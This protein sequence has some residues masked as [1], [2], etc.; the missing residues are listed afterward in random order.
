VHRRTKAPARGAW[1]EARDAFDAVLRDGRTQRRARGRRLVAD[2]ADVVF[3]SRERVSPLSRDDRTGAARVAVWLAWD[4]WVS[5]A[6]VVANG[7]FQRAR[8]FGG[9]AD[10]LGAGLA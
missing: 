2:P 7:W 9:P 8:R 3:D 6:N 5:M 10:W 4:Y 1:A